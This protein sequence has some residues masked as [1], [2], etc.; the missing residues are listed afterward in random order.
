MNIPSMEFARPEY[1]SGLPF[2]SAGDLLNP[3]I[4]PRPPALQADSLPA[5]PQG[6]SLVPAG[7]AVPDVNSVFRTVGQDSDVVC[8]S[9]TRLRAPPG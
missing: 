2:P 9:G 7:R 5:E 3:G 8:D 1:Q 4:E 6:K